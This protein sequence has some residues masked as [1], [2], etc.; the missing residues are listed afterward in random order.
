MKVGKLSETFR[1]QL[2]KIV[3]EGLLGDEVADHLGRRT[4]RVGGQWVV[5]GKDFWTNTLG[6]AVDEFNNKFD[7]LGTD[8]KTLIL[9]GKYSDVFDFIEHVINHDFCPHEF[10]IGVIELFKLNLIAYALDLSTKSIIPV[11]TEMEQKAV[12]DSL[13]AI[14]KS[15]NKGA[16]GHLSKAA[17]FINN[18][19]YADSVRESIHAVES[20]AC[21]LTNDNKATLGAALKKLE[22]SGIEIHLVLS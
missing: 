6:H 20:I 22:D 14:S 1:N 12:V 17:S 19:S 15:K 11:V 2:W 8:Y 21:V 16:L 10:A 3:Y 13:N 5:V 18:K 9:Q 4:N 7:K